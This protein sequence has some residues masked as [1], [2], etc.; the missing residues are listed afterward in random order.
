MLFNSIEFLICFP[1]VT[2]L[3]F[4]LPHRWRLA[5]ST[6]RQLPLLYGAGA[7]LYSHPRLHDRGGL[8]RRD[9]DRELA[10]PNAQLCLGLSIVANVGVLTIFKYFGFINANLAAL[11]D[12]LNLV[13]TAPNFSLILPVGLSFHTFQAMSY[14]IE[15][16]RGNQKAE[17][18]F[19]IFAALRHVLPPARRWANQAA[20]ESPALVLPGAFFR[21]RSGY[22]WPEADGVGHVQKDGDRGSPGG[23]GQHR[24]R[25]PLRFRWFA[26]HRG[27]GLVRL[28]DLLRLFRVLR[29]CPGSGTISGL[30]SMR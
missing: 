12:L 17:R 25:N 14:T 20:R 30:Q 21:L 22:Q 29:H 26:A 18:S 24:L 19:G 5:V 23:G 10:R 9:L 8:H 1:T 27:H 3:Y 2:L 28:P 15:V 4:G 13:Y 16:Y 6:H 11:A 7:D